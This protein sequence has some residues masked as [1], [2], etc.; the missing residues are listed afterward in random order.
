MWKKFEKLNIYVT[1]VLK[2][3]KGQVEKYIQRNKPRIFSKF[4]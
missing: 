2:E 1:G 4:N 3:E